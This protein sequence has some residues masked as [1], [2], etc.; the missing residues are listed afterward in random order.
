MKRPILHYLLLFF[1]LLS[2]VQAQYPQTPFPQT[3]G[4]IHTAVINGTTLYIGGNFTLVG[5]QAR[6]N[7]ASINLS[8]GNVNTW[9]PNANGTVYTITVQGAAAYLGGDFTTINGTSR[10]RLASVNATTGN[11]NT[12][13]PGASGT[14]R[15]IAVKGTTVYVGGSFA[16]TGGQPRNNLAA[17]TTTNNNAQAWDPNA[18]GAVTGLMLSGNALYVVGEFTT[19]GGSPRGYGAEVNTAGNTLTAWNPNADGPIRAIVPGAG[20]ILYVGGLFNNIGGVGRS[21][22]A[23]LDSS[24]G[25]AESWNPGTNG[26]VR[27]LAAFGSTLYMVGAF[28][29]VAGKVR[30]CVAAVN[31]TNGELDPWGPAVDNTVNTLAVNV[32]NVVI[33]GLFN[34]V[35]GQTTTN[36]AALPPVT[37]VPSPP[38]GLNDVTRCNHGPVTF[39]AN[40]VGGNLVVEWSTDGILYGYPGATSPEYQLGVGNVLNIW[41]RVRNTVTGCASE[42]VTA[43]GIA[44]VC[45]EL[46]AITFSGSSPAG[47]TDGLP[48]VAK[49]RGQQDVLYVAGEGCLYVADAFNHSIRK[50]SATG[51]VT[52]I[53]GNGIRGNVNGPQASARFNMPSGLAMDV[54][55]N[56]LYIADKNNH[57]IRRINFTT[58]QVETVAGSG[59]GFADGVGTAAKLRYP[60]S[61]TFLNGY[62]YI[63]DNGNHA[64]RCLNLGTLQLTTLAGNGT[65][66]YAEGIGAA[67]QF[68]SPWTVRTNGTVLYV[69]DSDNHCIRQ[70]QLSGQTS[71]LA[72]NGSSGLVNGTLDKVRFNKPM[73]LW[74]EGSTLYITDHN[75][76]CVRAII[77]GQASTVSGNGQPGTK[78]GTT[79]QYVSPVS[80]CTNGT[81]KIYV[82]DGALHQIREVE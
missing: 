27:G 2:T 69:T 61:I 47:M 72:G 74:V 13:N 75:N 58:G 48:N 81:G 71:T 73:G 21:H 37:C 8:T 31:L 19:I 63:A 3:N 68:S 64:I 7:V 33:G 65:A 34:M 39:S 36:L 45:S 26:E 59:S 52:T 32:N 43:K 54:N 46:P 82:S 18:N 53:A 28:T 55:N 44:Q 40:A 62:L 20:Q 22:L 10:S 49:F 41:A 56:T 76:R 15:A 30:Q 12:W 80:V 77:A 24:S 70:V 1:C 14:V 17:L 35:A 23:A 51:V 25:A 9:N 5:G 79:S 57:C 42:P 67:A 60:T 78:V 11:L 66:G 29:T 16:T 38:N 50:V 4:V 6:N